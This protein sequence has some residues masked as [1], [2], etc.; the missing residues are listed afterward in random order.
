ML[1]YLRLRFRDGSE[2]EC[3]SALGIG[4]NTEVVQKNNTDTID[5]LISLEEDSQML[6]IPEQ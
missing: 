4:G 3:G 6:S 2:R 1:C 5:K